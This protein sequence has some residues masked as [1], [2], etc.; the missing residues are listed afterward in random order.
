MEVVLDDLQRKL[1]LVPKSH[2]KPVENPDITNE[3]QLLALSF[4]TLPDLS[5]VSC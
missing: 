3:A 4:Q 5:R 2:K 1:S